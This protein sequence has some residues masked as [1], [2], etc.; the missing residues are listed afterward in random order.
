MTNLKFK[1]KNFFLNWGD[2]EINKDHKKNVISEFKLNQI[3]Y[4]EIFK[5]SGIAH[6]DF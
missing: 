2:C 1:E 3:F 6:A 5:A 4:L